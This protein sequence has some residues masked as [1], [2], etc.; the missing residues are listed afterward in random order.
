MTMIA[1]P[2]PTSMRT[3]RN[4]LDMYP[5]TALQ[6]GL[7]FHAIE[8]EHDDPYL[9]RMCVRI[10]GAI[11]PAALRAAWQAVV[12]R[13]EALRADLE[14]VKT[15][16]P[17][18]IVYR[19]CPVTL[20]VQS[21]VDA[22]AAE[23]ARR[24][25]A[26]L[27][28]EANRFVLQRAADRR[29]VLVRLSDETSLLVWVFHH[30][31][32]DGWSVANVLAEVVQSYRARVGGEP[33]ALAA[34]PA[35]PR[36]LAWLAARSTIEAE[37]YF[38]DAL[39]Q[40]D[41]PAFPPTF[42]PARRAPATSRFAER[43]HVF[44]AEA[45]AALRAFAQ[46][47]QITLNAVFQ[48]ALAL[49]IRAYTG[50]ADVV[51]GATVAG[52]PPELAGAEAMVGAFINT[53]PV[54]SQVDPGEPA[55]AWLQRLHRANGRRRAHEHLGLPRIRELAP[56]ARH[57]ALFE[58]ILVFESFPVSEALEGATGDGLRIE[59]DGAGEA[60]GDGLVVGRGRNNYPLTFVVLPGAQIEVIAAYHRG[61]VDDDLGRALL[62]RL[63]AI[64][65]AL[66]ALP[67]ATLLGVLDHSAAPRV[68]PDAARQ[69]HEA[70]RD[71]VAPRPVHALIAAW[72]AATP[73]AIAARCDD[74]VVT[75][76]QLDRR[77]DRL[78]HALVARGVIAGARVGVY[79]PRSVDFVVALYAIWKCGAAYVPLEV[80]QPAARLARL[81]ADAALGVVI[82]RRRHAA[83][84]AQPLV[85]D[86]VADRDVAPVDVAIHVET[87]A[88]LIYTSGSTGTPKGVVISHRA[89][90]SYV[91][92]LA[93]RLALPPAPSMAMVSTVAADLGH[94]V[95]FGALCAGGAIHLISEARAA[96]PDGFA[97]Y[98]ER[99]RV[100]VLKIVPSHLWGLMQTAAPLRALPTHTLVIGGEA[101]PRELID[102]L[103]AAPCRVIN[104]YGP[105]ETTVGVL[106]HAVTPADDVPLPLGRPLPRSHVHVLGPDLRPMPSGAIGEIFVGGAGLA[107]GY[108]HRPDLTADRFIPDPTPDG[109]GAR[110]YRTGDRGRVRADGAI[111]FLGRADDQIKLRGHRIELGEITAALCRHPGV[112]DARVVL[113]A[114]AAG[115]ARL[116]AYLVGAG[117][118]ADTAALEARL[119]GELP[120]PMIPAAYVW[121]DRFPVTANGKIDLAGLPSPAQVAPASR[122]PTT[123]RERTLAAIWQDVL[124]LDR[125]GV[126]DD[127]FRLGGDSILALKIVSR[128]RK[129]GFKLTPK[130][131][132]A[133]PTIAQA[134]CVLEPVAPAAV[135]PRAEGDARL[136][137]IQHAFLARQTVDVHHYNQAL[138]LAF[139]APVDLALLARAVDLVV[140][141]HDALRLRFRRDGVTWRQWHA[142]AMSPGAWS[143]VVVPASDEALEPRIER[144]CEALQRSFDLER[145]PLLRA[146]YLDLGA[147][148]D[149][150]LLLFAH[151]L[152]VDGVSWRI[153]LEDLAETYLALAAG[154]PARLAPPTT[155]FQRWTQLLHDDVA[156]ARDELAY[157]RAVTPPAPPPPPS[158]PGGNLV[159]DAAIA[160]VELDAA[161]T[162]ALLTRA[163]AAHHTEVNDVLLAALTLALCRAQAAPS[164]LVRVEG[165]GR[166]DVFDGVDLSRT[167]GWFST[168]Y[169]VRLTPVAGDPIAT[170][171]AV[172]DHLRRV[173]RKGLGYGVLRELALD[174]ELAAGE[175]PAVTFNYLGQFDTAFD[176]HALFR[177]APESSGRRR[178]P[179][180][181]RDAWFVVNA[182]VYEGCL[183]IDWE[184]NRA[185]HPA[186]VVE[187]LLAAYVTEL[188]A[189]VARCVAPPVT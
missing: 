31:L 186:A 99:H 45:S 174:A 82:T 6:Q 84:L 169:P 16:E 144:A 150:R 13:H 184:Y 108:L 120:E 156:R 101:A 34:V 74:D 106:T 57:A 179:A 129:A 50:S 78:A 4:V 176:D 107:A 140:G 126:D 42:P 168:I 87:P 52:R 51:F 111:E 5:L 75:Y 39:A 123:D 32:L 138:L 118:D 25:R 30:V 92:G 97:D 148:D 121:L 10:T 47:A 164:L 70:T 166:E 65:E 81:V 89:L 62:A 161:T 189:L 26:L 14:W 153:L 56:I 58:T 175:S 90:H 152:V 23:Q 102:R 83:A 100:A 40:L 181:P 79:L 115:N 27:D 182:V 146:V 104:H 147:P 183:R 36:Y 1:T 19:D 117:S 112:V 96:D 145:G 136:T 38:R 7:L 55:V 163:P 12:D 28:D 105:T 110:L 158:P 127:F 69:A 124:K 3:K 18:Q 119:R 94:T 187:R 37:D 88:Y 122:A 21:W 77:A 22:P 68:A 9:V 171:L 80:D 141:H 134:A 71:A 177:V 188:R 98:L 151:H 128:T 109:Q 149:S 54:R 143:R 132:Y 91:T 11:D 142:D 165:H 139:T 33:A 93:S 66:V 173:P 41:A 125:L 61:R 15:K 137:P 29:I 20:D 2:T 103:R 86:D 67:E 49:L 167:V 155:S 162:S 59:L 114:G 24:R 85:L 63:I 135:A 133:H 44:D 154:N 157:W 73:D 43:A 76:A 72:V 95:L 180:S 17:I 170:L 8:A 64:V 131:L 160:T 35:F 116:V 185:R 53:V 178:S 113:G 46:R 159:G 60:T 172:R 48:G 130:Q